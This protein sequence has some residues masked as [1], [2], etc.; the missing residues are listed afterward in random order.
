MIVAMHITGAGDDA[1]AKQADERDKG[2]L[3]K[4]CVP[5]MNW[6]SEINV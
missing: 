2:V 4:N 6:K 3:F 1:V 5:F